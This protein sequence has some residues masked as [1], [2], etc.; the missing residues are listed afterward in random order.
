MTSYSEED[1]ILPSL[2]IIQDHGQYGLST[3]NL[4]S[5]LREELK[6]TGEDLEILQNRPD[7]KFSQ[8]VRNLK[9]HKTLEK[10][11]YAEFV[12]NKFFITQVGSNF[13][14]NKRDKSEIDEIKLIFNIISLKYFDFPIR[15]KN[16]LKQVKCEYVYD[17][18]ILTDFG[19]NYKD[20][21]KIPNFGRTSLKNFQDFYLKYSSFISEDILCIDLTREIIE[22]LNIKNKEKINK[23]I[24]N[25][26]EI[27]NLNHSQSSNILNVKEYNELMSETKIEEALKIVVSKFKKSEREEKIFYERVLG[28]KTLQEIGNEYGVTRERI[29]QQELKILR[30][31]S[32]SLTI[33]NC[34]NK[35]TK[36]MDNIIFE[37][38]DDFM[39]KIKS[40]N[41]TDGKIKISQ[42]KNLLS[43]F[44][45]ENYS[46]KIQKIRGS[47]FVVES[48]NYKSLLLNTIR[49]YFR[50]TMRKNGIINIPLMLKEI[51]SR[52]FKISK[53]N[54][55]DIVYPLK[56]R[57]K[58]LLIENTYLLPYVKN[59]SE[60]SW[61]RLLGAIHSTM[62]VTK[63]IDVEELTDC[64]KRFRRIDNFSP[65]SKILKI[66]CEKIGYQINHD[67]IINNN[68]SEENKYLVGVR[69]KMFQMFIDNGR[70]MTYEQVLEKIEKYKLNLNSVHVLIYEN[71][72]SLP[73]KGIYTL[74]GTEISEDKINDLDEKRQLKL[75]ELSKDTELNFHNDGDVVVKFNKRL[76][77]NSYI[78]LNPTFINQIPMGNYSIDIDKK[79]SHIKVFSSRLWT[80][81]D[82]RKFIKSYKH[83]TISIKLN[84]I[85]KKASIINELQF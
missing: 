16:A 74:A 40:E 73:R 80:P 71:L 22:S 36:I 58:S 78:W 68:Y 51:Q 62:S 63:K 5:L 83:E 54:L 61:N 9:S 28:E 34:I 50:E 11:N 21:L 30:K 17:L 8:K 79:K 48:I 24:I 82:L 64:L 49:K 10:K 38:S 39:K 27:N 45:L 15:S 81:N 41:L 25:N 72:F 77:M 46:D 70:V 59:K 29:R 13:L 18:N 42:L 4:V 44:R 33:K 47:Y 37:S 67:Y 60:K 20:L 26:I 53:A 6:P 84:L 14:K 55:I 3:S 69:K 2:K 23:F 32:S 85:E 19:K 31:V 75:K 65:P 57:T 66:I 1:L 12:D 52:Q 56:L 76:L 35:I 7:D 43:L